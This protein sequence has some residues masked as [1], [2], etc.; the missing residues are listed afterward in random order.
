MVES[1]FL[2][3][4][5]LVL[6]SGGITVARIEAGIIR[7]LDAIACIESAKSD[8]TCNDTYIVNDLNVI[9]PFSQFHNFFMTTVAY[10]IS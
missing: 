4:R 2:Q 1:V 10:Y 7:D 3:P 9:L 6:S 5:N 8:T